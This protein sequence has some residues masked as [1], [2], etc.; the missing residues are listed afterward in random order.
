MRMLCGLLVT[1]LLFAPR[2][3][4]PADNELAALAADPSSKVPADAIVTLKGG[5]VSAGIGYEWGHGTVT[6]QGN[7]YAFCIRGL[8]VGEVGAAVIQADGVIYNMTT[9]NDFQ[10]NYSGLSLGAAIIK[11]GTWAMH[12]NRRGVTMQLQS[13]VTG[14]RFNISASGVKIA[15]AGTPGCPQFNGQKR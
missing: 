15:L 7:Q 10:G 8:T 14:L 13:S 6:Y 9:L 3:A 1:A 2:C 4:L 5:L 11:G 12:K